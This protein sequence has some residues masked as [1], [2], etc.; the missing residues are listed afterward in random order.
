MSSEMSAADFS[1]S[2]TVGRAHRLAARRLAAALLGLAVVVSAP[3]QCQD[4]NEWDSAHT[5]L[6]ASAPTGMAAAIGQWRALVTRPPAYSGGFDS[7]AGF[8]LAYPGFPEEAKLRE[9]AEAAMVA[10]NTDPAR[11][12]AFCDRFP[13][14][15]NPAR[16]RYAL[17]LASF[18]RPEAAAVARA[19]WRGGSMADNDAAAIQARWG[20]SFATADHDARLDALLWDGNLSQAR[21]ALALASSTARSIG[22]ARLALQQGGVATPSPSTEEDAGLMARITAAANPSLFPAPSAPPAP[23]SFPNSYSGP[24][25]G[26]APS[27]SVGEPT[28]MLLADPGYVLDRARYLLRHGRASEA[29]AM[30]ADHP[31][32]THAALVPRKWAAVLLA[33]ARSAGVQGAVQ[34]AEGAD[35]GFGGADVSAMDVAVRD[36]ATSLY[37]LGGTSALWRLGEGSRAARLFMD[38]A[39]AARTPQTRAKGYYWAGRALGEGPRAST[40]FA[41][42]AQY[43][44]Q[45]YGLLALERLGR[46]IPNLADPPHP[47]PSY[48]QR[49]AFAG[50]TLTRAVNEVARDADWATTIRFFREAAAQAHGEVGDVLVA[51]QARALG[52]RDYGVILGQ[53]AAN[54]GQQGFRSVAFP[55]IPVPAGADWTWVHAISRQESQFSPNALSYAGARGLMQLMPGTA[56]GE[57][58]ALGIPQGSLDDP[59]YNMAVGNGYFAHLLNVFAGSYPLAVAAYNA[60]PGNVGRW[61]RDNGDPRLGGIDWVTWVERIPITQTRTYVQHV[62]ENAVVY[63]AMNPAHAAYHGPNPLSYYLGKRTPG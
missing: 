44:D 63:E 21:N 52:R 46:P 38:Y 30:I 18:A 12:I 27:F 23:P 51:D 45:Y 61:L 59:A 29:A 33:V 58:R 20:G 43:P 13:P 31:P 14:L 57:A 37:W 10:G 42:A 47:Q 41:Q 60:G 2:A 48:D 15:T 40:A 35:A 54:D 16:A 9:A 3:A 55:L 50:R 49:S 32:Y 6:L 19:A 25:P 36:D 4:G 53:A 26:P 22:T 34:A 39:G 62:L 24:V 56:S 28:P 11:V 1:N 5:R 8:L 17:A 7:L